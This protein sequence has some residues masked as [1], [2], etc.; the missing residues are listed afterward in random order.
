M[1]LL[2]LKDSVFNKKDRLVDHGAIPHRGG[3]RGVQLEIVGV[4]GRFDPGDR[5]FSIVRSGNQQG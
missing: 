4:G 3:M 5:N 2:F 1:K